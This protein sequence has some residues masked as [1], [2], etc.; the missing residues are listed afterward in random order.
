MFA[1][2]YVGYAIL[3]PLEPAVWAL[4][5]TDDK[6]LRSSSVPFRSPRGRMLLDIAIA[7]GHR[8]LRTLLDL[9][10]PRIRQMLAKTKSTGKL[11]FLFTPDD[12]REWLI[13]DALIPPEVI[14]NLLSLPIGYAAPCSLSEHTEDVALVGVHLLRQKGALTVPGIPEA[15]TLSVTVVAPGWSD[16][17]TE[18]PKVLH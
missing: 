4:R 14:D 16:D 17:E 9:E 11:R 12:D 18:M 8:L 7:L 1:L 5:N 3:A 15:E 13:Y 2:D 10:E 6:D